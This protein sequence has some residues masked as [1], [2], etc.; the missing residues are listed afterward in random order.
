[1]AVGEELEMPIPSPPTATQLSVELHEIE[2]SSIYDDAGEVS[3]S[4]CQVA[5]PSAVLQTTGTVVDPEGP[6]D[7]T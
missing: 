2:S 6:E 3:S 7:W 1:M 5:P 4:L